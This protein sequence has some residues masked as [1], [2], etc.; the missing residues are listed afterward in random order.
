LSQAATCLGTRSD[1]SSQAA[2]C[3]GTR[4]DLSSQAATCLGT[5]RLMPNSIKWL[6]QGH[7]HWTCRLDLTL[8]YWTPSREAV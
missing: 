2:T 8:S 4:S 3:L 6:A 7:N 1:L 5:Q